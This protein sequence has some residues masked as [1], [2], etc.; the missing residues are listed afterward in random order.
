MTF[1][2][3]NSEIVEFIEKIFYL[4]LNGTIFDEE[5][6]WD[7]TWAF[8]KTFNKHYKDKLSWGIFNNKAVSKDLSYIDSSIISDFDVYNDYFHHFKNNIDIRMLPHER[9]LLPKDT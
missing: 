3:E 4:F 9:V 8:G 5:P 7:D 2:L 1:N 6:R